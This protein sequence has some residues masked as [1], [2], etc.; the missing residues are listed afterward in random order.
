M[1]IADSISESD[2]AIHFTVDK[3]FDSIMIRLLEFFT[4]SYK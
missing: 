3:E 4:K 1:R 2:I